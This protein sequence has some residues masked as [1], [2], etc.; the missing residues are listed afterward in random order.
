MPELA[1]LYQT[2][3]TSLSDRV[4]SAFQNCGIETT[5]RATKDSRASVDVGFHSLRHTFVSLSANAGAPLAVVQAIVGH[6]NPAMTRHYYHESDDALR[7]AV[8]ALPDV[9]GG[10]VALPDPEPTEVALV[11]ALDAV[12]SLDDAG[13]AALARAVKAEQKRRTT[14]T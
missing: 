12:G 6:S 3:D 11:A 4:Q 5:S 10:V 2:D 1:E 7:L 8:G 9:T 14:S 13:L